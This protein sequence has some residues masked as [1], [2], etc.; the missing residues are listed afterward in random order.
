MKKALTIALSFI[1][2]FSFGQEVEK[3][4][5]IDVS[6]ISK[7]G[8]VDIGDISKVMGIDISIDAC[9]GETSILYETRTYSI[10]SIGTQC[11]M[12]ENLN[13]GTRIDG[14]ND[15]TN[16]S[17]LEKYCYDDLESNCDIYGGLYQWDEMMQ[18]STAPG[19]QGICPP[20]WHLP[21]DEEWKQLEGEVDSQ[22]GYPDSEW[23]NIGYRGSD[24]G[25]HLKSTTEWLSNG[26]GDDSFGFTA[27]PGG[28]RDDDGGFS[29]VWATAP[30]S[31]RQRSTVVRAPGTGAWATST[32]KW[33]GT[34]TVR[35]AV[36]RCVA[37]RTI[38]LFGLF[39][40][41]LLEG[42][43]AKTSGSSSLIFRNNPP[44]KPHQLCF[45]GNQIVSN[46]KLG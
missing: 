11:W 30:S 24:V 34:T 43:R 35:R 22:Y 19:V 3:V 28:Y 17:T 33:T 36:S 46:F 12:A 13:V 27:L 21:T 31:G 2:L 18:Y 9:N 10:V 32:T 8:G 15:Q 5:G 1:V 38:D 29:T 45:A 4:N 16:N 20:G 37:F 14:V 6:N 25:H 26:N 42:E 40:Y 41:F 39:D 23:N 7:I 44:G